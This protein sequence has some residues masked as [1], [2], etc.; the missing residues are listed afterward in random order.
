[1]KPSRSISALATSLIPG[2]LLS[3]S[4]ASAEE[5]IETGVASEYESFDL[6]QVVD[7]I[8][9]GWA[10]AFLS[11]GSKLVTERGGALLRIRE[12]ERQTLAGLPE[13]QVHNQGGLLDVVPHPDHADNGWIYFTY[14]SGDA[15]ATVPALARARIDGDSLVDLEVLFES[16]TATSPGRHYGSR[17]LFLEDGTLLM[18]IG[19]RGAEPPRAQDPMDHSGSV[20]RL[21]KD[22]SIPSD[23]PFVDTDG[24]APEIY[25]YGHRNIQGIVQHPETGEIWVTEHGPRGGDEL[26]RIEPGE[27]YGWPTAT[28]GRDYRTED[29]FPDAEARRR[30]GMIDP[31]FEFLP[32]LAP[33]GLAVVRDSGFGHWEGNLLAGGLRAERILRLTIEDGEVVHAE[34][35]LR[36]MVGRIR[37]V[38]Q[39]PDGHIYVLNDAADG[40]LYRLEPVQ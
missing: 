17:I 39:G 20:V 28:L 1:M 9:H 10:V 33:S 15:D 27:N 5:V 8:S 4:V 14:S 35:L 21:H 11:D 2:L 29:T 40:A 16:N 23:N 3:V 24:Y 37:D 30:E 22:G 34:E 26:N 18:T 7:D 25:S 13:I 36:D 12:Q 32:T 6:I 31:A 19:D 38:R